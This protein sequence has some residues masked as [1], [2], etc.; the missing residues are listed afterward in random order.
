MFMAVLNAT[1]HS[2]KH[3]AVAI[4]TQRAWRLRFYGVLVFNVLGAFTKLG[5][6]TT[7]FVPPVCPSVR[8]TVL[9]VWNKWS[10]IGRIFVNFFY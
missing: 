10:P 4:H 2:S 8:P 7:I 5:K 1:L 6:A 9:S 3:Q